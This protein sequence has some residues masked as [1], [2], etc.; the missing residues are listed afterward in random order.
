MGIKHYCG[1]LHKSAEIWLQM[2]CL[3]CFSGDFCLP[4]HF[5][6]CHMLLIVSSVRMVYVKP[7]CTRFYHQLAIIL[8]TYLFDGVHFQPAIVSSAIS[9]CARVCWCIYRLHFCLSLPCNYFIYL[10]I[11]VSIFNLHFVLVRTL[12][13]ILYYFLSCTHILLVCLLAVFFVC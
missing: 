9:S 4:S 6:L 8:F 12:N 2:N 7:Q 3:I 1:R 5:P 10:Y 11:L 13:L